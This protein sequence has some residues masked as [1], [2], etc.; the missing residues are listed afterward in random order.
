MKDKTINQNDML[1]IEGMEVMD[2]IKTQILKCFT[3]NKYLTIQQISSATNMNHSSVMSELS[4]MR[5]NGIIISEI[6]AVKLKSMPQFKR[7]TV[8]SLNKND[9]Q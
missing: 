9:R 1:E 4:R 8:Y 5:N 2:S 7:M 6:K 3:K